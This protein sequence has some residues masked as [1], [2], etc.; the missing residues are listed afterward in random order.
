MSRI[1]PCAIDAWI[2]ETPVP[3]LTHATR[4]GELPIRIDHRAELDLRMKQAANASH[5]R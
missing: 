5:D 2:P 1:L 3:P 4:A